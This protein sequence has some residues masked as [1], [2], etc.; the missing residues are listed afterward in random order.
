MNA[1]PV[2]VSGGVKVISNPV[3]ATDTYGDG[4]T[5]KIEVEFSEAVNATDD[6]LRLPSPAAGARRCCAA[7]TSP[8]TR[9]PRAGVRLRRAGWRRGHQRHLDRHQAQ[10]LVGNRNDDP[11]TGTI[12]SV[13]TGRA[14]DL[15]HAPVG[16]PAD[17]NVDGRLEVTLVTIAVADP[18]RTEFTA[19]LDDVTFT[20]QRTGSTAAALDVAVK[21][22][23][24]QDFLDEFIFDFS[25][26]VTFQ[27]GASSATLTVFGHLFAGYLA[28][29]DGTLTATVQ[30]Q[31]DTDYVAGSPASATAQILVRPVAVTVRLDKGA[32]TF[33]E[34]GPSTPVAVI[35]TLAADIPLPNLSFF[36]SLGLSTTDEGQAPA[37]PGDLPDFSKYVRFQPSDFIADMEGVRTARREFQVAPVDDAFDEPDEEYAVVLL[38]RG[39][40]TPQTVALRQHDGTPCDLEFA[41]TA[42]ATILDND[43]ADE[44]EQTAGGATWTL[45]GE[46]QPA[47]GDTYTYSITLASGTKPDDEYVGFYLPDSATN[48]NRLGTDPEA[49][50]APQ[51]FC[52]SFDGSGAAGIWDGAGGYD[53]LTIYSLLADP[54]PHTA[55]ATLAIPGR[56]G[57]IDGTPAGTVIFFG[58]LDADGNPSTDGMTIIVTTPGEVSN[59]PPMIETTSPVEAAENQTAVET[60]LARND[61]D[62]RI[63]WTIT[64]GADADRFVL[65]PAGVLTFA[66]APDYERPVDA[67]STDPVNDAENNEYVV[68]VTAS[69]GTVEDNA[70]LQLVVQVTNVDEKPAKPAKPTVTA[71]PG[72]AE[73]GVAWQKPDLNGGPEITGYEVE[74][75]KEPHGEWTPF[76]SRVTDPSTTITGLTAH[77]AYQVRVRALNGETDSDWSDPSDAVS[78]AGPTC[79]AG[80]GRHLVRGRHGRRC[81]SVWLWIRGSLRPP[82]HA[83]NRWPVRQEF[84]VSRNA[85]HDRSYR[86]RDRPY[87]TASLLPGQ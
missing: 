77:T 38:Q 21:L 51:Q 66:V 47:P 53:T 23:Q 62:E 15:R 54:S 69:D 42:T 1:V 60:L 45:T 25:P 84:H 61:D 78:T 49:C 35:A 17:H 8:P 81:L 82:G 20:L 50:S 85:L 57:A 26:T 7:G 30:V 29:Q 24:D 37:R 71:V 87:W 34:G 16:S 14:A 80:T 68:F 39:A 46:A 31:D 19:T 48:A 28:T 3:A 36:V 55:T 58:P 75:R 41:C 9:P 86:G 74:Y 65:T 72:S 32:Y 33:T 11:Q 63:E 40:D 67:A 73:L 52:A 18:D 4:E 64:G 79:I 6:R 59:A 5:I 10:T 83:P 70:E 13:A 56:I 2:I 27:A 12:T 22:E 43:D 44:V 76:S